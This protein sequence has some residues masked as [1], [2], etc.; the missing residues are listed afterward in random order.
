VA[1]GL[2]RAA[3]APHPLNSNPLARIFDRFG[4][5]CTGISLRSV[6]L[7][8]GAIACFRI[9]LCILPPYYCGDLYRHL[10]TAIRANAIG[11]GSVALPLSEA[12]PQYLQAAPWSD[13]AY[14]YPPLTLW[15]FR[16]IA[17]V[18]PTVLGAKVALTA[19]E[20]INAWLVARI[21]GSRAIGLLY[22]CLPLSIW[23]VSREGQVEP[24]QNIFLFLT[25]LALEQKRSSAP[26]FLLLAVQ[27][28]LVGIFL[29]PWVAVRSRSSSI[30]GW[31]STLLWCGAA[32][33]PTIL[34]CWY[35][36]TIR[37]VFSTLSWPV[38]YNLYHWNALF[39]PSF[40]WW[41]PPLI[42]AII[43]LVF[44][45]LLVAYATTAWH[46]RKLD[47]FRWIAPALFLLSASISG[48]FQGWYWLSAIPL[49]LAVAPRNQLAFGILAIQAVEPFSS[50]QLV[51]GGFGPKNPY[52]IV[53]TWK[54]IIYYLHQLQ[55]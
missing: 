35:Y 54:P 4:D 48:V 7:I 5:Y 32:L 17:F 14:N 31:R 29:L 19:L 47:S 10:L 27:T 40:R 23:W 16:V 21:T 6:L 28:K 44:F 30:L 26:A 24:L 15:F 42:V 20:A 3:H 49:W 37:Q 45:A 8:A 9:A 39:D 38:H 55:K 1:V 43:Q 46:G 33:L 41:V 25:L 50:L 13:V 18:S 22:W 36:P 2:C 12:S 53:A 34:A 11:Q 51:L 52:A